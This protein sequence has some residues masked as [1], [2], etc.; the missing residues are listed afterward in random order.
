MKLTDAA[1]VIRSKNAGPL[2]ITIDL[3][4]EWAGLREVFGDDPQPANLAELN[5]HVFWLEPGERILGLQRRAEF[6]L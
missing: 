1:T 3:M 5:L 2:Q 6:P 4:F